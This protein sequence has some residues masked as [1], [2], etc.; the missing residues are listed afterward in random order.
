MQNI[1]KTEL[2]CLLAQTLSEYPKFEV[3]TLEYKISVVLG[4]PCGNGKRVFQAFTNL[5]FSPLGCNH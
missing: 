5:T 3:A 2:G 4:L 1:S